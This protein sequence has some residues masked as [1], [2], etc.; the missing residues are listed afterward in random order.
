MEIFVVVTKNIKLCTVT[1]ILKVFLFVIKPKLFRLANSCRNSALE[2][3]FLIA[4][5]KNATK[6][7]V[8][9]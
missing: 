6:T 1:Q 9:K 5:L 3:R 4:Y 2:T 7:L 8:T